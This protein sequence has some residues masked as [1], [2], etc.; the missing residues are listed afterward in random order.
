[1][2]MKDLRRKT[3]RGRIKREEKKRKRRELLGHALKIHKAQGLLKTAA[4]KG[5]RLI[6]HGFLSRMRGLLSNLRRAK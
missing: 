4:T 6:P 2:G 5:L 1:M 3:V